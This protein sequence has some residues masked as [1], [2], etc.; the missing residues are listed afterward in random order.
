[1]GSEYM[2]EYPLLQVNE[3]SGY[4]TTLSATPYNPS[5][6][7]FS[8]NEYGG[9]SHKPAI[10]RHTVE[11]DDDVKQKFDRI[12]E[13]SIIGV[14]HK[15]V[16]FDGDASLTVGEW[17]NVNDPFAVLASDTF[18]KSSQAISIADRD[19]FDVLVD[20]MES[21]LYP[22]QTVYVKPGSTTGEI[23]ATNTD[24]NAKRLGIAILYCE[25]VVNEKSTI[26]VSIRHSFK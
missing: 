17:K 21:A 22:G 1:M 7:V 5:G 14:T 25:K 26:R 15:D 10:T 4:G 11:F 23:I 8:N 19:V 9:A 13:G 18:P 3:S 2:M 12:P 6:V 16:N 24:T 20:S